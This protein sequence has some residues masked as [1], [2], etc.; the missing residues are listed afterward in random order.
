VQPGLTLKGFAATVA[1]DPAGDGKTYGTIAALLGQ[2]TEAMAK[3]YSRRR[4]HVEA[5]RG[6]RGRF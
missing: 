4:R 5:E 1:D 6:D 2:K 3:H